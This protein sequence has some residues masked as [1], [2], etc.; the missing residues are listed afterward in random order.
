MVLIL[1][2]RETRGLISM[3]EAVAVVEEAFA[4]WGRRRSLNAPRR[5]IHAP[6]G[7]RVSVH[8]GAAPGQGMTGLFTHCELVRPGPEHQEYAT[9]ADPAYTLF[10]AETGDLECIIVGELTPSDLPDRRVMTGIRTAATSIVGTHHLARPDSQVVGLFGAGNQAVQHLLALV[11]VRPEIHEVR[12]Y[13][14]DADR[15]RAF[16]E[17]M[18]PILGL[19]LTPVESPRQA[20]DGCDIVL[21]CTNSSVPVFDGSWLV[22]GQHVTTIIGS[23]IGLV[24]GGFAARKRREIDDETVRRADVIVAASREQVVQD[25]QADLYDPVQQGIIAL[26]DIGDLGALLAGEIP[27]RTASEQI[28]LFKNNAGQGVADVAIGAMVYRRARERDLG[29]DL[30][31]TTLRHEEYHR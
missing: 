18:A 21:A 9:V 15:R 11:A 29:I 16:C 12:V 24:E 1:S 10:N 17:E 5:R 8:Q 6:S 28:T 13:R 27:G 25:E 22:P 14:R 23:N 26:E 31:S 19:G 30:A 20:V 3:A 7:V 4:E 2:A